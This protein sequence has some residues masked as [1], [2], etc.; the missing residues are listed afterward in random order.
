PGEPDGAVAGPSGWVP[1]RGAESGGP[2]EA[3]AGASGGLPGPDRAPDS[4]SDM[5]VDPKSPVQ[6]MPERPIGHRPPDMPF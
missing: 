2:D 5:D 3:V 6:G 4:E 1:G